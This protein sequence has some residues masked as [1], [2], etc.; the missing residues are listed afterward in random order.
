M[1]F[2][3]LIAAAHDSEIV[4]TFHQDLPIFGFVGK[5]IVKISVQR[6]SISKLKMARVAEH[7][8]QNSVRRRRPFAAALFTG[9]EEESQS[10]R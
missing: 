3:I 6:R 5:R 2:Q 9:A 4:L 10:G 7:S 1:I 8:L